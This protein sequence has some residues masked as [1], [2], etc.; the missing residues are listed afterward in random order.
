MLAAQLPG[1]GLTTPEP[2]KSLA[3]YV[4]RGPADGL[5]FTCSAFGRAIEAAQQAL[6]PMP[7]LKPN[8]AMIEAAVATGRRIGLLATFGPTLN[9]MPAEFPSGT[10]VAQ[11]LAE[12]AFAALN[13]GEVEMHNR[14]VVDAAI[15]DLKG[16][17]VIALAQSSMA[18]VAQAIAAATGKEVLTSPD[19]AVAKLR[20]L[21]EP[22]SRAVES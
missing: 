16:C 19:T 9:T 20:Y 14:L 17:D 5:L 15:R 6:A 4:A 22:A 2:N 7:V 3:R 1:P 21:L 12:G 13:A 11:A 8:E 10:L 18:P